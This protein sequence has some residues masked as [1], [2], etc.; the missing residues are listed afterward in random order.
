M[1]LLAIEHVSVV[2]NSPITEIEYSQLHNIIYKIYK[3]IQ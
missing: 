3:G 1:S 2:F